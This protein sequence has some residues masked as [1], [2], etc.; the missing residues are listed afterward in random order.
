[1]LPAHTAAGVGQGSLEE[2]TPK[3]VTLHTDESE[4]AEV[5]QCT[6]WMLQQSQAGAKDGAHGSP[7]R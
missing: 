3:D 6:S 7:L 2:Q 4:N 5:T 1:M